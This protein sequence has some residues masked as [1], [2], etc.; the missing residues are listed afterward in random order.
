MSRKPTDTAVTI[1]AV[2]VLLFAV[3]HLEALLA[4]SELADWAFAAVFAGLV[5]AYSSYVGPGRRSGVGS[6]VLAAVAVMPAFFG[7]FFIMV[8]LEGR[9]WY[10]RQFHDFDIGLCARGWGHAGMIWL[11]A[12]WFSVA[13]MIILPCAIREIVRHRKPRLPNGQSSTIR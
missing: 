13:V 10:Y 6:F 5:L 8:S 11:F 1:A 2:I 12:W 9:S 4:H 3:G 7:W